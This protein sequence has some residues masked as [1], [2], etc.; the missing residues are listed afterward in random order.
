VAARAREKGADVDHS[1]LVGLAPAAALDEA[2][3]AH[4][5][6]KGFDPKQQIVETRLKA[7]GL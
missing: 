6:L 1:E 3:A 7:A 5:Q 4:V 2:T